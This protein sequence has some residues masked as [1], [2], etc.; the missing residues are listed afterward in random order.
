M[1]RK[2][3]ESARLFLKP[4]S[5]KELL[6]IKE[7][8]INNIEIIIDVKAISH[9]VKLAIKKKLEKMENISEDTQNW[10]TYWL[11]INK[12]N[13]LG[14]GFIGFK[15]LLSENGYSE[16]GYSISPNYRRQRLMTEALETLIRW[17]HGFRECRG[18][19]A[20]VSKTNIGSDKILNNCNFR[21]NSS[22]EQEDNYI[23]EFRRHE[24]GN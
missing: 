5:F 15:G 10:C 21:V 14:V 23:L 8:D 24:D 2:V 12:E 9:S 6:H 3:L 18:I 16:V 1:G 7:N 20:K 17:A 11:I 13:Q 22:T 4:L 19:I